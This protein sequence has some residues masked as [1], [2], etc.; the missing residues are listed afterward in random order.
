[1]A[2]IDSITFDQPVYDV[3]AAITV[4]IDYT[5]DAPGTAPETFTLSTN[6]VDAT[7]AV[8]ASSSA[9]FVVNEPV[10]GGDTLQTPTDTGNRAWAL[11]SDSGAVGVYTATA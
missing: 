3:G 4:T 1:M 8:V 6:L 11:S 2:S 10:A 7:G 5:P 9:P